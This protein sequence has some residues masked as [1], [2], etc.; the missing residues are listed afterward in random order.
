MGSLLRS[1]DWGASY[2]GDPAHWPQSLRPPAHTAP[3][4]VERRGRHSLLARRVHRR[5]R[6]A[7]H[8]SARPAFCDEEVR[9]SVVDL[10]VTD[11]VMPG[12][13]CSTELARLARL[14]LPEIAALFTSG[15]TENAI[16]HG[17]RLDYGTELFSKPC[18]REAMA[19]KVRHVLRTQ[20]QRKPAA[21][22]Q[23][24]VA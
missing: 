11:V 24:R 5:R 9:A 7:V 21:S 3:R 10:L 15:Y 16:A 17:G 13:V 20:Q 22:A 14:R 12:P 4:T 1:H 6:R 23:R 2:L 18:T 8:Q 19:R